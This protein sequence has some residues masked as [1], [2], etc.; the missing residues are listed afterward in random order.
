MFNSKK[1]II[2]ICFFF[3]AETVL[4]KKRW[5][6]LLSQRGQLERQIPHLDPQP[7]INPIT[8]PS[9]L[10]LFLFN[11]SELLIGKMQCAGALAMTE[12]DLELN[13]C[14]P[15]GQTKHLDLYSQ[16]VFPIPFAGQILPT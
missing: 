10:S 5:K 13:C 14:E 9:H 12:W 11:D 2:F 16:E 15:L 6:L 7:L 3:K 8:I 1:S 4:I